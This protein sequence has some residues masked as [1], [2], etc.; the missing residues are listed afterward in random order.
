MGTSNRNVK[1]NMGT[2]VAIGVILI[3][4]GMISVLWIR[5][6]NYMN[7]NHPDYK[8]YDLFDEEEDGKVS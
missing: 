6:I 3:F 7:K 1:N 4:T 5:G 2:I 8:G